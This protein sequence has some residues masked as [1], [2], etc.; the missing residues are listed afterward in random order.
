LAFFKLYK[1][2]FLQKRLKI[3]FVS[4]R[5]REPVPA[6]RHRYL[7]PGTFARLTGLMDGDAGNGENFPG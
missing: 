4:G 7:E 5:A 2:V 3:R 1:K 6:R